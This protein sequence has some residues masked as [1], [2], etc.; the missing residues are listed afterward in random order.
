MTKSP[1]S[2]PG[3]LPA[4]MPRLLVTSFL[5]LSCVSTAMPADNEP[6]EWDDPVWVTSIAPLGESG[7]F[8]ASK[9][10]GLLLREAEVVSFEPGDPSALT[11]LY[12]HPSAVWQVVATADGKTVA[13]VDYRGS[14][15]VYDVETKQPTTHETAFNRWCQAMIVGPDNKSLVAG[16]EAGEVLVW[17][18]EAGKVSKSVELDKHAVT[19]L[20]ISPDGS[21]LA[22]TDG[23]GHVHLLKW[24][25]L[26]ATGK[27]EVSGETAWCVNYIE[28]GEA[29]L[30]GSA[31][32]HLYRCQ[33][34]AD[35]EPQSVME[36]SD[37]ITEIS[38]APS[39]EVAAGEIGGRV[40][41]P[42]PGGGEPSGLTASSGVWA[43]CWNGAS[44]LIV[45]TRKDGV[46]AAGRSWTW[47]A[48]ASQEPAA[49]E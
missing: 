45:G 23:A 41:F 39:G 26:D 6:T 33:S 28:G 35:A 24:P 42:S 17:D 10:N 27:I 9:A 5:M 29:L 11:S 20:A 14:L 16:N 38:V 43:V 21:Q 1:I 12:T 36:G 19:G 47:T 49:D 3:R 34:K 13:S 15:V 7:T 31:D 18:M 40:W 44:E 30:I 37:W 8:V 4:S 22:A 46:A 25:S 48:A 32:R 2:F